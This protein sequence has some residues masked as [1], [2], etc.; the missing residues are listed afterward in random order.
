ARSSSS[1]LMM[2]ISADQ[3]RCFGVTCF[4]NSQGPVSDWTK[5]SQWDRAAASIAT[6]D[7]PLG[8]FDGRSGIFHV[9]Y[10]S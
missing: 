3:P 5:I 9:A 8:K 10:S 6:V 4:A 2:F 1:I 7:N